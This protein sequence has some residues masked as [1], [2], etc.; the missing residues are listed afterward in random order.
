MFYYLLLSTLSTRYTYLFDSDVC[1]K[2]TPTHPNQI[3]FTVG[4]LFSPS[5]TNNIC[6][7]FCL[8]NA[9]NNRTAGN[10]K[11]DMAVALLIDG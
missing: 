9:D 1:T 8:I 6:S 4:A 10:I 11:D 5:I 3:I 7:N 2:T